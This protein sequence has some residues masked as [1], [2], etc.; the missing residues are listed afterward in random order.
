MEG[1]PIRDRYV[2]LALLV[3]RE[4]Q[5]EN[6]TFRKSPSSKTNASRSKNWVVS[7]VTIISKA[8]FDLCTFSTSIVATLLGK[9]TRA[10][11]P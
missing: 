11:A 6:L 3:T 2:H 8:M 1:V 10:V 5:V 9:S 7:L 4:A